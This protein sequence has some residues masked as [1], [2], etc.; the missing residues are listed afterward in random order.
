MSAHVSYSVP[1]GKW[2]ATNNLIKAVDLRIR[3]LDPRCPSSRSDAFQVRFTQGGLE[4]REED[5]IEAVLGLFVDQ[6]RSHHLPSYHRGGS[7][8]DVLWLQRF[9]E[10]LKPDADSYIWSLQEQSRVPPHGAFLFMVRRAGMAVPEPGV[11]LP[12]GILKKQSG[13]IDYSTLAA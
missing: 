3:K 4:R 2:K 5:S 12:E 13:V 11:P 10:R 7:G 1:G 9:L 8:E 6:K